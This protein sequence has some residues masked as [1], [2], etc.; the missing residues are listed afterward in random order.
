MNIDAKLLKFKSE[1]GAHLDKIE[2]FKTELSNDMTKLI[3]INNNA[4]GTLS[5]LFQSNAG[6]SI[7]AQMEFINQTV[8]KTNQSLEAELGSTIAEC[9]NLNSGIIELESILA[10]YNSKVSQ[11][12]NMEE[13][14]PKRGSVQGEI[15]HL[16]QEFINKNSELCSKHN[17]LLGKDAETT[18]LEDFTVSEVPINFT[19]GLTG[20]YT[21]K[22]TTISIFY[23]VDGVIYQK[24][25]PYYLPNG[26]LGSSYTIAY[27]KNAIINAVGKDSEMGKK[28][29][30]FLNSKLSGGGDNSAR[31]WKMFN[32]SYTKEEYDDIAKIMDVILEGSY[33]ANNCQSVSDYATVAA[34]VATNSLVHMKYD[35]ARTSYTE[36]FGSVI[37]SGYDCIG[38]TTWAYYQGLCKVYNVGDNNENV[39]LYGVQCNEI[40]YDYGTKLEK[41]SYEEISNI[42]PGAIVTRHGHIGIVIGTEKTETGGTNVVIAHSRGTAY[43]TVVGRW[44]VEKITN[45]WVKVMTAEDMT[46]RAVE[47]KFES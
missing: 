33:K 5:S 30:S 44:P 39:G 29:I 22:D 14:D 20:D 11:L 10:N 34:T 9:K 47:G 16:K 24:V 28:A 6:T 43:G 2:T 35:G 38:F 17:T 46:K 12:N 36:G 4:L 19:S 7:M 37:R 45:D 31:L 1:V 41:L 26:G 21:G 40:Y 25:L 3:S 15:S 8:K 27:D 32:S 23:E 42:K 18:V 13:D